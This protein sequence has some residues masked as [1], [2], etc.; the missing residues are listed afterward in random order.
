VN[1]IECTLNFNGEFIY[2]ND[3][4]RI[5]LH[6][7]EK[8][9]CT[10]EDVHN[11]H[12]QNGW[13]GIGYHYFVRKDGTIYRGRPENAQGAHCPGQN[14]ESIG[15]CA[16]GEYMAEDMPQ[17]QKDVIVS[18]CKDICNRYG[19]TEIAGHKEY[20]STDCPGTNYPLEEIKCLVVNNVPTKDYLSFGDTGEKVAELQEKLTQLQGSQFT[21]LGTFDQSTTDAVVYFQTQNDLVAD[22]EVGDYTMNVIDEKLSERKNY[23]VRVFTFTKKEDADKLSER[24]TNELG[25]YSIVEEI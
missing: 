21:N 10:I 11:W 1:I 14:T 16:E 3:P 17:A 23:Q 20:Y 12:L 7:A 5:I 22:G 2:N 18:L 9:V 19:I 6:H 4:K 25:Y 24:I 13:V 8:S 15:I